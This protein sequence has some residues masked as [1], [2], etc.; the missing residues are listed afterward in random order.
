MTL[1]AVSNTALSGMQA[2]LKRLSATANNIANADTPGYSR[3]STQFSA[4]GAGQAANAPVGGV[5]AH[6]TQSTTAPDAAPV[7]D[8][9]AL[10]EAPIAFKANA[11]VFET[12]ADLWQVLGTIR[13][14]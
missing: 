1:S 14:D 8:M 7:Q 12:G 2:Q 10:V 11:T 13:R 6:V 5:A 9:L 4:E 3:L